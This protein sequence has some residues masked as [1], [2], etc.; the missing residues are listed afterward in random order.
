MLKDVEEAFVA[1]TAKEWEKVVVWSETE[2]EKLVG[3]K[4]GADPV[5][6][7]KMSTGTMGQLYFALRLAGYRSFARDP[8]P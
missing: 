3:I 1:M 4:P 6:V 7:E 5:S 8:F 2:G